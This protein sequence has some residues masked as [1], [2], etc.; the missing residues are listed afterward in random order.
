[1]E[2]S[3]PTCGAEVRR[4]S[5]GAPPAP[6]ARLLGLAFMLVVALTPG[7]AATAEKEKAA[8]GAAIPAQVEGLTARGL[9]RAKAESDLSAMISAPVAEIH[10]R[11]G[12]PFRKGDRLLSFDCGLLEAE[13]QAAQAAHKARS[14]EA[15]SKKR[16]LHYQATGRLDAAVASAK[17]EEAAAQAKKARLRVQ[18]CRV[19]APFDGWLVARHV[20]VHETPQAGAKL[21]TIVRK[22]A[23][24]VEMIVPS[25]WLGWIRPGE[26]FR[27]RVDGLNAEMQG[28]I[29]RIAPVVEEVSQTVRV[30]GEIGEPPAVVR[31]GMS[32]TAIFGERAA[33][34]A[35]P[36]STPEKRGGAFMKK[37][38]GA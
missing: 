3:N 38:S 21:L 11:E 35:P 31:H 29:T 2:Y 37:G 24:E 10:L 28:R 14:L 13:W 18:Q 20:D 22:G 25:S 9:L 33:G 6:L 32:G 30:Y 1:M 8:Q 12:M 15:R 4:R 16:L 17:A 5:Q 7:V 23:L 27:F 34:T 26:S 19:R 36:P